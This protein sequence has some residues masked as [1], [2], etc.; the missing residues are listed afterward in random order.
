MGGAGQDSFP[1]F[2]AWPAPPGW[3]L[4]AGIPRIPSG[5]RSWQA[6]SLAGGEAAAPPNSKPVQKTAS[7]SQLGA[8]MSKG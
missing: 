3:K 2:P 8:A 4:A 7:R 6:V 1:S 5:R